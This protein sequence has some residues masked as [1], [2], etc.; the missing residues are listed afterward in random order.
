MFDE[1]GSHRWLMGRA[2]RKTIPGFRANFGGKWKDVRVG[3]HAAFKVEKTGWKDL[4]G[5]FSGIP[6]E[7]ERVEYHRIALAQAVIFCKSARRPHSLRTI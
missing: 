4:P 6:G 7:G 2:H 1:I 5:T 3:K